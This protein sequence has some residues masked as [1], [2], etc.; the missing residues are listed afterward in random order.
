MM[1]FEE[2]NDTVMARRDQIQKAYVNG[3][4]ELSI[5]MA[6]KVKPSSEDGLDAEVKASWKLEEVKLG[7]KLHFNENQPELPLEGVR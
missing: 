6:I 4:D 7:R 2:L 1:G 5:S 3:E